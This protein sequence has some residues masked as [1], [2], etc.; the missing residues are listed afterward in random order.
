[1][2][3]A[4]SVRIATPLLLDAEFVNTSYFFPFASLKESLSLLVPLIPLL[5]TS[6]VSHKKITSVFRFFIAAILS[7]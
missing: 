5:L 4:V 2:Q 1:M 6:L 7:S 3:R